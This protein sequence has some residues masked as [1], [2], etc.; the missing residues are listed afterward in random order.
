M[1]SPVHRR[2]GFV[3]HEH[4]KPRIDPRHRMQSR[5]RLRHP[6]GVTGS[7]AGAEGEPSP[8]THPVGPWP[9]RFRAIVSRYCVARSLH[10]C[11][12]WRRP[13]DKSITDVNRVGRCWISVLHLWGA[14]L[15]HP[16]D[17]PRRRRRDPR[18]PRQA[19]HPARTHP[20]KP[21]VQSACKRRPGSRLGGFRHVCVLLPPRD[22]RPPLPRHHVFLASDRRSTRSTLSP[23]PIASPSPRPTVHSPIPLATAPTSPG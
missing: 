23:A 5:S 7:S 9:K 15:R 8:Q 6:R 20:A 18:H 13:C 1:A 10:F 3:E 22:D 21:A 11:C 4:F 12:R 2:M 16:G 17:R 14:F 19:R